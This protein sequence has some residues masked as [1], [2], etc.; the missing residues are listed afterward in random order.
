MD[1]K[2]SAILQYVFDNNHHSL[3]T[4]SNGL[5]RNHNVMKGLYFNNISTP[6][7]D[8]LLNFYQ[9]FQGD[10]LNNLSH[11]FS[12]PSTMYCTT[13]H[14]LREDLENSINLP[15]PGS[16]RIELGKALYLRNSEINF[17]KKSLT[18]K[19]LS[20]IL[21]YAAGASTATNNEENLTLFSRTY[22]SGGGLYPI[23]L[24]FY[25]NNVKNLDKGF[26]LYN[27]I[28]HTLSRIRVE[29]EKIEN[30]IVLGDFI[31][32]VRKGIDDTSLVFFFSYDI[33]INY[34]KYG[35]LSLI[36]GI[37]DIGALIQNFHLVSLAGNLGFCAWGGL[38]KKDAE[39]KL[40]LDGI[41]KHVLMSAVLGVNK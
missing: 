9:E 30:M 36:L 20:N 34:L 11:F 26:Y 1:N 8:Y 40:Y 27:P 18:L 12:T 19:Q 7:L 15:R 41:K 6:M 16:L 23:S 38:K 29:E 21:H 39:Q 37:I 13:D 3:Y 22:A 24:Y 25:A 33:S 4:P 35:E 14:T 31:R 17:S 28:S 32:N 5:Y 10:F 2:V